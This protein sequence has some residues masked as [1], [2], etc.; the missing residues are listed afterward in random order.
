MTLADLFGAGAPDAVLV[1]AGTRHVTRRELDRAV[2]GVAA[3]LADVGATAGRPVAVLLTGPE[4][5]AALFGVWRAG[6]VHVP[7]NPRLTDAEVARVLAAVP[8]AAV[9]TGIEDADRFSD[10]PLVVL[11]DDGARV[12]AD[13]PPLRPPA[14]YDADVALV[15]LTSGT[16]GPPKP[17]LLRHSAVRTQLDRV[18]GTLRG[19]S[20][21]GSLATAPMPNL[22]PLSLSLW[23]GIYNVCFAFLAGAPVV[24]LE[25]F[26]PREFAAL[27]AEHQVRSVVL[28]PAAMAML[29]DEASIT[30]LAP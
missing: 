4:A 30:S 1:H 15:Q 25:R 11:D 5:V 3:A 24:L 6:L 2:R 19:G 13:R 28:P 14:R 12:V 29:A 22:I 7:L 10:V 18:L 26:E 16:T 21:R 9:V 23:A 27:V 20:G 8:V 17:V